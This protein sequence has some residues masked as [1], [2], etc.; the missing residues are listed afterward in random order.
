MDDKKCIEILN[1]GIT[2]KRNGNYKRALQYY[3]EAKQYNKFNSNIYYNTGKV[4]CGIGEFED[5]LK[6]LLTYAHLTILNNS[7]MNNP[8]NFITIKDTIERIRKSNLNLPLNYSFPENW[9]EKLTSDEKYL[10]LLADIN[11]TFYTGF[12]FLVDKKNFLNFYQIN[13]KQIIDLQNGLLGKSSNVFLKNPDYEIIFICFGLVFLLENL[14]LDLKSLEDIVA[15]YFGDKFSNKN[16]V[17][18]NKLNF[19]DFLDRNPPDIELDN[20][21]G[22]FQKNIKNDLSIKSI[23]MGY[24]LIENMMFDNLDYFNPLFGCLN[25]GHTSTMGFETDMIKDNLKKNKNIYLCYFALPIDD[26]DYLIENEEMLDWEFEEYLKDKLQTVFVS[27][28]AVAKNEHKRC[29]TFK[30]LYD[31]Q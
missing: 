27:I 15:F 31:K 10:M 4:L 7:F 26:D 6:N 25:I 19:D 24:N 5:A 13:E 29:R 20:F 9:F 1:L 12:S 21:F 16:I 2:E 23:Y 8:L 30:F 3:N 22:Q 28:G 14:K 18:Q 11:L 17:S